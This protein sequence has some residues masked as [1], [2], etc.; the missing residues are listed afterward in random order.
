MKNQRLGENENQSVVPIV[1]FSDFQYSGDMLLV[2]IKPTH[3]WICSIKPPCME[4]VS[5]LIESCAVARMASL[6]NVTRRLPTEN[7]CR[8]RS[9]GLKQ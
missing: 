5:L 1:E 3:L 2:R 9:I 8:F 4:L 6:A 7:E